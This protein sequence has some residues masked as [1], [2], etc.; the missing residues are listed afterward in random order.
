MT[1]TEDYLLPSGVAIKNATEK[2][3]TREVSR[4]NKLANAKIRQ[5]KKDGVMADDV[6][7]II[8][9]AR[10]LALFAFN[11]LAGKINLRQ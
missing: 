5:A 8:Q 9:E 11:R 10:G 3:I 7:K 4:L 2:E 6:D 1:I